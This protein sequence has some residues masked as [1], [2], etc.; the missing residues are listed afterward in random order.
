MPI[1]SRKQ[2]RA[3]EHDVLQSKTSDVLTT[4]TPAISQRINVNKSKRETT[5]TTEI[6]LAKY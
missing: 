1:V 2:L 4:T 5:V 3:G 6:P